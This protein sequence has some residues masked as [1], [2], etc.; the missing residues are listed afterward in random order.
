MTVYSGRCDLTN[1][2]TRPFS[3]HRTG[4]VGSFDRWTLVNTEWLLIIKTSLVGYI[5]EVSVF[6]MT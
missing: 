4:A 6:G 3:N 1:I 5:W 2:N